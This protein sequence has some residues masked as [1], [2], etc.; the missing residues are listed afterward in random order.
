MN[1]EQRLKKYDHVISPK[2]VIFFESDFIHAQFRVELY[3]H[4]IKH[5]AFFRNIVRGMINHDPDLMKFVNKFKIQEN[6]QSKNQVKALE[7]NFKKE[8]EV[9]TLFNIDE[10]LSEEDREHI[11]TILEREFS[12]E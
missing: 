1:E 2:R 11:F 10:P 9:K 3:A 4:R 6:Y 5:G 7:K 12:I 8:E